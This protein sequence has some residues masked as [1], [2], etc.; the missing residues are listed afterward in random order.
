MNL[1]SPQ[2]PIGIAR[3]PDVSS[4]FRLP[5]ESDQHLNHS[6]PRNR[7]HILAINVEGCNSNQFKVDVQYLVSGERNGVRYQILSKKNK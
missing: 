4:V 5:L 2:N 1:L 6:I 3:C 7:Y